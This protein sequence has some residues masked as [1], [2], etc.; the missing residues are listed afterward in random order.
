MTES[1]PSVLKNA[2][3]YDIETFPNM[4]SV[5]WELLDGSTKL[6]YEMSEYCDHRDFLFDWIERLEKSG[7]CMI[8]FNSIGFDWPVLQWFYQHQNASVEQVYNHAMGILRSEDRF[9]NIIWANDR[10]VPQVDLFRTNHFDNRAKTTS[11]KA[12]QVNMRSENVVESAVPFGTRLTPGQVDQVLE[13]NRHDVHETKR[14]AY[15]CMPALAFRAGMIGQFGV[16]VLNWNDTKIGAKILENRLGKELCYWWDDNGKRHIRQ[17]PRQ[18]I[19]LNDIIFPYIEFRNPEFQRVLKYMRDQVLTPED[20]SDPDAPIKTKGVFTGLSAKVGGID[21]HFG[22]GGIH[23][24][25]RDR[26]VRAGSGRRI[27]DIDVAG[28]YPAI[29]IANKLAPEHLGQ[30]YVVEYGKLPR[31]RARYAKG[32]VQNASLKLAGNGT[33]GNT[34]NRYSPF[35]DPLYTMTVTINGQ[36]MLAMLAEWLSEVPTLELIQC[37]TDGI[38]YSI[39]ENYEPEAASLCRKWENLTKLVLEDVDYDA[40][41]L[42]DVNTYLARTVE[43]KVKQKGRLWHPDPDNYALSISEASPP[44]W[45][46]DLS[47]IASVRAAVQSMLTGIDP[48]EWLRNHNDPFD[49]MCRIRANRGAHLLWGDERVQNTFRYYVSTKGQP[50]VKVDPPA[51][52]IGAYKRASGVSEGE[53]RSIMAQTK[54]EW[55]AR[56]CTKNKSIYQERRTNIEA[57]WLVEDCC[58]ADDFD[59]STVNYD[60]YES[61]ARKLIVKEND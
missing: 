20:L 16:D 34:N 53:Y 18:R 39:H 37:N 11:L 57:G 3:V 9:G 49:F 25:V 38:T 44:A 5:H 46:K 13:Y 29:A 30:R 19:A 45:H 2:I 55:D 42:S 24:S 48:G 22:T 4:I 21:F 10:I 54:G 27:R 14:F 60:W 43:G 31:E 32:T 59:W 41:W 17:S 35:Y 23:G 47:N 56:V 61:E 7:R 33:Y 58:C 6:T 8:G 1:I 52:P 26:V 40:M 50:L 15:N 51:G 12:L 36:L 28:M